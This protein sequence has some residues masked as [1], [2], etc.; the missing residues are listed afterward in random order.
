MEKIADYGNIIYKNEYK[1]YVSKKRLFILNGMYVNKNI[2]LSDKY[3]KKY[4][5]D[6]EKRKEYIIK[7]YKE[8]TWKQ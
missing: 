4:C 5:N 3:Y 7:N 2:L 1:N 6:L 8:N